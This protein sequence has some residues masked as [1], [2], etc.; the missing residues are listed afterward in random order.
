MPLTVQELSTIA[1]FKAARE[2]G[3]LA[4]ASQGDLHVL[5]LLQMVERLNAEL[6]TLISNG[7]WIGILTDADP[8]EPGDCM[9]LRHTTA[10]I[11][12]ILLKARKNGTTKVLVTVNL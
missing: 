1:A 6:E 7:T 9:W 5:K 10:P 12:T 2:S 8:S 3:S 11:P 4:G